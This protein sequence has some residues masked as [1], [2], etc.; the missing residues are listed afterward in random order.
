M[1]QAQ[2]TTVKAAQFCAHAAA[3]LKVVRVIRGIQDLIY[4]F[5]LEL[6]N[7]PRS[8]DLARCAYFAPAHSMKYLS[9]RRTTRKSSSS[10]PRS[11]LSSAICSHDDIPS[12]NDSL[13]ET[14]CS[15]D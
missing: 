8:I 12:G 15:Q 3:A 5:L 9:M 2:D 10:S 14:L 11:V 1:A 6:L 13:A 4:C 7:W